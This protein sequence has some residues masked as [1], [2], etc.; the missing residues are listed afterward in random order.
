MSD[1]KREVK[2]DAN[3]FNGFLAGFMFLGGLLLGSVAGAGVM[4]LMA[5]QSGKK[6]RKQIQRKGRK[7]RKQTTRKIEHE[8]EQVRD[9]AHRVTTS[10]QNQ[11]EDLQQRG[12]DMVDDQKERWEPVLEAGKTAVQG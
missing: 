5:P 6:T 12:Q 9:K 8:A 11:A 3:Q 2:Q 4:L 1:K 10:I 7:V